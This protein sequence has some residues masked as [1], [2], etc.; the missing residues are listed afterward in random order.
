MGHLKALHLKPFLTRVQNDGEVLFLVSIRDKTESNA[1]KLESVITLPSDSE[2]WLD[3]RR[4]EVFN[5]QS[6]WQVYP[7]ANNGSTRIIIDSAQDGTTLRLIDKDKKEG[8]GVRRRFEVTP[9]KYYRLKVS[10]KGQGL[11]LYINFYD[12]NNSLIEKERFKS[13]RFD[14]DRFTWNEIREKAPEGTKYCYAWIYSTKS[15]LTEV[16]VDDLTFEEDDADRTFKF[17]KA[18]FSG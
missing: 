2:I 4:L 8:I 12:Q 18:R 16:T 5:F 15:S 7:E 14:Q 1:S 10:A 3:R 13:I 9:G 6:T 11:S 17:R